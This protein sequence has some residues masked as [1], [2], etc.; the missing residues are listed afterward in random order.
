MPG[1]SEVIRWFAEQLAAPI[2][3]HYGQT[4]LG[5][6]M[7]NHPRLKHEV[8]PG[9]AGFAMPGYRVA[10][11]DEAGKELPPNCRACSP[12]I[13]K[14]P[15]CCGSPGTGDGHSLRRPDLGWMSRSSVGKT[16]RRP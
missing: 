2:Y 16:A 9:S 6:V 1:S 8:N 4:E 13:S 7:N 14:T 11:L 10:V 5:M 3:D 15:R 12:S